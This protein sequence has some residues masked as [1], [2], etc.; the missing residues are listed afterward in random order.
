MVSCSSASV[1]ERMLIAA[2]HAAADQA[3]PQVQGQPVVGS[4]QQRIEV[5]IFHSVRLSGARWQQ[6]I[7]TCES[8]TRPL[9][10]RTLSFRTIKIASV[11]S[12][13][14]NYIFAEFGVRQTAPAALLSA[15][16]GRRSR[17]A[18][19]DHVPPS[20]L[21]VNAVTCAAS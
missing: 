19:G 21:R 14:Q 17:E 6:P 16:S 13:Q 18:F 8:L 15:H 2:V 9:G 12:S 4:S 1:S 20:R 11:G 7:R 5:D 3:D 10:T